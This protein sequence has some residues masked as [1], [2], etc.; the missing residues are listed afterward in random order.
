M[1]TTIFKTGLFT[2]AENMTISNGLISELTIVENVDNQI[3]EQQLG[4]AT[5]AL[6]K[7]LIKLYEDAQRLRQQMN[8]TAQIN[9]LNNAPV[10]QGGLESVS[11]NVNIDL[12]ES[13][14]FIMY[15]GAEGSEKKKKGTGLAPF[16]AF[17]KMVKELKLP[18][19]EGKRP[20]EVFKVAK[21][22][23]NDAKAKFGPDA[24]PMKVAKEAFEQ[25]KKNRKL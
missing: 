17:A 18:E 20:T 4:G 23:I 2:D 14:D 1:S 12:T 8:S 21:Q 24:D 15:G 19:F 22:Y 25:F 5:D 10:M 16:I 3:N 13:D 7:E 9:Q 6:E 11:F